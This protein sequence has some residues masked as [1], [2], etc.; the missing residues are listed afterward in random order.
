ME[1]S[2]HHQ[3]LRAGFLMLRLGLYSAEASEVQFSNFCFRAM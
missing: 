2:G 1:V 3:N